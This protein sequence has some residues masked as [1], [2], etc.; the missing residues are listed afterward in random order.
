[1]LVAAEDATIKR[2]AGF[3]GSMFTV[4]GG[5]LQMAGSAEDA[6]TGAVNSTLIVDGTGEGV[7]GSIVEVISGNYALSDGATLTGN[8]TTGDG[9]AINNSANAYLLGGTIKQTARQEMVVR[10]IMQPVQMYIF[11]MAQLQQTPLQP[12]VQFT[13]KEL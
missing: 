1:M 4:N 10:L 7:T 2:A 6:A 5:N 3:I 8:T 9:S 11:R 13:V 12:A